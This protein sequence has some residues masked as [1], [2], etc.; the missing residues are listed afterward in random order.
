MEV[1]L[2]SQYLEISKS[3]I[4]II[5]LI[6]EVNNKIDLLFYNFFKD[7]VIANLTVIK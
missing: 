6:T 2:K 4:E 7:R 5:T 3:A 1:L